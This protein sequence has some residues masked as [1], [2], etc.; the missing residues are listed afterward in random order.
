M[1]VGIVVLAVLTGVV[2]SV[3]LSLLILRR[4][5]KKV[6]IAL[7]KECEAGKIS[8]GDLILRGQFCS[9]NVAR[10]TLNK[11]L[12]A[13][14]N[15]F[16]YRGLWG[17]LCVLSCCEG[18]EMMLYIQS[19]RGFDTKGRFEQ[20]YALDK[21]STGVKICRVTDDKIW[22]K[23]CVNNKDHDLFLKV[24]KKGCTCDTARV[25][26]LLCGLR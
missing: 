4:G 22:A 9:G 7:R 5:E 15:I 11:V 1:L 18:R 2:L 25:C 17:R 14:G 23:I 10:R 20:S 16:G 8:A 24:P 12:F 3:P 6:R 19:G 26:S 13:V 21:E